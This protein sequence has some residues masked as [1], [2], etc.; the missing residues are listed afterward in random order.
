MAPVMDPQVDEELDRVTT[1]PDVVPP[2]HVAEAPLLRLLAGVVEAVEYGVV[3]SL[4]LLAGVVLVRTAVLFLSRPGRYPESLI[5]AVDGILVVIIVLD[6]M[7]TVLGVIRSRSFPVRPFL[8]IGI[9]A[10]VRDI[11]SASARLTL[12]PALSSAS[13]TQAITELG[14]GVGVVLALSVGLVLLRLAQYR[15]D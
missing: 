6:I 14:V 7:R 8:V 3:A 11:L 15:D 12:N 10:A 9:L 1:L 13:F 4:L 2:R 5:S